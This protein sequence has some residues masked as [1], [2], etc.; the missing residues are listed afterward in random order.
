LGWVPIPGLKAGYPQPAV[1]N[2]CFSNRHA[3]VKI[4]EKAETIGKWRE[5][6]SDKKKSVNH[7]VNQG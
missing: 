3:N 5:G 4:I 2:H 1:L 6:G 7:F